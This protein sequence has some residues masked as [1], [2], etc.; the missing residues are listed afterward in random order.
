MVKEHKSSKFLVLNHLKVGCMTPFSKES[1]FI[2]NL[3][4]GNSCWNLPTNF[5]VTFRIG[6]FLFQS[7]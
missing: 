4:V 6:I 5:L 3:K 2:D 1:L 7:P